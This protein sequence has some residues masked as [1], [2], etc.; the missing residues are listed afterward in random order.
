MTHDRTSRR[1]LLTLA[2]LGGFGA[3][4]GLSALAP[5]QAHGD[6]AHA[7]SGAKAPVS[8][9]QHDWGRQGDPRHVVRTVSIAMSDRMRFT[10][11]T[12]TV[13]QGQTLRLRVH[14]RGQAMHELVIGTRAELQRHAELMKKHPGM[15]HDEPYM[16]HVPPGRQVDIVWAFNRSGDLMYGCLLPGHWE[17]GMQG[18]IQVRP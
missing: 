15:E 11:E 16:A 10:P 18:R 5:A 3:L 4:A 13:R 6:A 7:G 17:S 9:Q 14:N 8:D 1:R 2:A 12:L